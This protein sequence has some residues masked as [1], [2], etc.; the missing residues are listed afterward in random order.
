MGWF[1]VGG[2]G[3]GGND[4]DDDGGGGG[5]GA[6]APPA[7]PPPP[8]P[9]PRPRCPVRDPSPARAPD[10]AA[11]PPPPR[12]QQPPLLTA[13]RGLAAPVPV[14]PQALEPQPW[15]K[16]AWRALAASSVGVARLDL[17]RPQLLD[18]EA[19]DNA[20]ILYTRPGAVRRGPGRPRRPREGDDGIGLVGGFLGEAAPEG[21]ARRR[22]RRRGE[23]APAFVLGTGGALGGDG[24]GDGYEEDDHYDDYRS[25]PSG[26]RL[27]IMR[28]W[29]LR[30]QGNDLEGARRADEAAA[31]K[32]RA[33]PEGEGEGEGGGGG[34][35][36]RP[37][38]W[39]RGLRSPTFAES[40]EALLLDDPPPPQQQ[41]QQQ[42]LVP[43]SSSSSSPSPSSSLRAPRPL[44]DFGL[45][46]SLNLDA[47]RL[48][49]VARLKLAG[50]VSIHLLSPGSGA[51]ARPRLKIGRVW[52]LPGTSMAL[53]LRY[54]CPLT[55]LS[56]PWRPPARV[57]L[58]L[59]N[60][61][62]SGVHLSPGGIELD[63]RRVV[64]GDG[65][66]LRAGLTCLFPRALPV[67]RGSEPLRVRV[68]R[69]SVKTLW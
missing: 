24:R 31:A 62:G 18:V 61:V 4:D 56:S 55:A 13:A 63:E 40:A 6:V 50:L 53:R 10:P 68:N 20:N 41:Q 26:A 52:R 35:W 67:P 34:R 66:A 23:T 59:D 17:R 47:S 60:G 22:R 58:R 36:R 16:G 29:Q 43:A 46:A 49:P 30:P 7:P 44:L 27:K 2:N 33:R 45:G 3:R 65:L 69:L 5:G 15:L 25:S 54:D 9:P 39:L 11:P 19:Y 8:P 1:G 21:G 32:G 42:H 57:L 14:A 51:G 64:L 48:E 12:Q 37:S 38:S 28:C